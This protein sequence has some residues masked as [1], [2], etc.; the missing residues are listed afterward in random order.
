[1]FGIVFFAGA[2][3][4]GMWGI[5]TAAGLLIGGEV[6]KHQ[7]MKRELKRVN[8]LGIAP[9]LGPEQGFG[10]IDITEQDV[11]PELA[12]FVGQYIFSKEEAT[13]FLAAL[14]DRMNGPGELAAGYN[15]ERMMEMQKYR[16]N[17]GQF[18]ELLH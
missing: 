7:L 18:S 15:F 6:M 3:F 17:D 16:R 10:I 8:R 14:Q 1:M 11:P 2:A 9:W 12:E 13:I 4:A 5:R